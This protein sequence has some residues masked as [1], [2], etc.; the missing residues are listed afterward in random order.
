MTTKKTGYFTPPD[1]RRHEAPLAA[2]GR[3]VSC[4]EGGYNL[5]AL[6]RSAEAHLRELAQLA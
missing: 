1:C 6:G 4:L 5:D 3:I 2:G